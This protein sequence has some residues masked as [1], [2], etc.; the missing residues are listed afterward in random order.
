MR[1]IRIVIA[2]DHPIFMRGLRQV[3]SADP[4]LEIVAEARDDEAAFGCIQEHQPDV[5]IIDI[6][7]PK[8]DGFDVMR[9]I[10]GRKLS[11]AVVFLTM[12]KSEVLC[13][14]DS[15][16]TWGHA[17]LKDAQRNGEFFGWVALSAGTSS[18]AVTFRGTEGWDEWLKDALI[19]S[20]PYPY[21]DGDF[22]SVYAGFLVM[23]KSVRKNTRHE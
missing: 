23:Y 5:A 9:A 10:E 17:I 14:Q 1:K 11:T 16:S 18:I 21:G 8:R 13:Q 2:D 20:V 4:T 3:L 6:D 12:H 15:K 22:G 19:A 7:M